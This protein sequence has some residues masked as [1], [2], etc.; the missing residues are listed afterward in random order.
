MKIIPRAVHALLDYS[1]SAAIAAAPKV[2]DF[3]DEPKARMLCK[4]MA[5]LTTAGSLLTR[6]ELGALKV[7]PFKAH[8]AFDGLSALLG[9]ASPW[10]LGFSENKKARNA[11]LA[12]FII[13]AI[14]VALSQPEEM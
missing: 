1:W 13:E 8:L 9:I 14:V 12:F 6:Y 11:V 10:L 5:S 3:N 4:S 7:L 2:L